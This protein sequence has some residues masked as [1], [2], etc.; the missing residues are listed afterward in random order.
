MSFMRKDIKDLEFT[1]S[2]RRLGS[3]RVTEWDFKDVLPAV[4]RLAQKEVDVIDI[5]KRTANYRVTGWDFRDLLHNHLGDD[6]ETG[7]AMSPP[8]AGEMQALILRLT[9]FL[10]HVANGIIDH[11]AH[12]QVKVAEIA[13]GVLRFKLILLRGDAAALIGTGGH[14]AAAIRRLMQA[15]GRRHGVHVLLNV[16]SHEEEAAADV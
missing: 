4:N 16:L 14:G 15:A 5:L 8:T 3:I 6:A 9:Q 7:T 13:P 11:P 10:S 12:A 1:Q 2:L